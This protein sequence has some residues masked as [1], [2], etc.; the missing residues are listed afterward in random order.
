[1]V[2]EGV[3][4][5]IGATVVVEGVEVAIGATVAV[6]GVGV[7]LGGH[8]IAGGV[9]VAVGAPGSIAGGCLT[10]SGKTFWFLY[11]ELHL[12]KELSWL[13]VLAMYLV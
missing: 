13:L 6:E 8:R 9:G 7:A 3:G 10:K 1:M 11:S 2:V 12:E 4:V 5:A